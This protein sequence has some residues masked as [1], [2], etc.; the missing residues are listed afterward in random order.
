MVVSAERAKVKKIP[1][2]ELFMYAEE[3]INDGQV[4]KVGTSENYI[5]VCDDNELPIGVCQRTISQVTLDYVDEGRLGPDEIL[6]PVAIIGLAPVKSGGAIQ[7]N[8]WV[9][10]GPNG[11]VVEADCDGSDEIIGINQDEV[12]AAGESTNIQVQ[13]IP[14]ILENLLLEDGADLLLEGGGFLL[15]E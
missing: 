6:C 13:R 1:I 5:V 2:L 15:L 14:E 7:M 4:V 3:P 10:T 12:G 11:T 8:A 9:R